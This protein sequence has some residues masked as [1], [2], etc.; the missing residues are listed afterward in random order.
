VHHADK[1]SR[2]SWFALLPALVLASTV[3]VLALLAYFPFAWD[4]PHTVR[5]DVH[6]TA[7]GD[8]WF[9]ERNAARTS[10]SPEWL[11]AAQRAGCLAIDLEARPRFP[12]HHPA[13]IMMLAR[14]FWHTS[15]AVGQDD[16]N[17]LLWLRRRGSSDN[18][19][20]PFMVPDVFR[21]NHWARVR[22]EID[23]VRLA[24]IVDGKVRLHESLPP[25]TLK[26]WRSGQI[27]LGDEVHSGIGWRGEIR[28]AEVTTVGDSIDYVQAGLVVPSSY[29][30]FPDHIAPFPPPEASEWVILVF[31][32]LSFIPVGLLIMWTRRPPVRVLSATIMAFG[33]AVVLALGKFLFDGRHTSAADLVLQL[34]G[35]LIGAMLGQWWL[36]KAQQS[37]SASSD[38]PDSLAAKPT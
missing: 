2:T 17:L 14:D 11:V 8:L 10:G 32:L 19:D 25:A 26:D 16:R 33:I 4:P 29:F 15:F 34:L 12:Q 20:P 38:S 27:A 24:V 22:V 23:G 31:H 36:R 35:G 37:K 6:R 18:G 3:A 21:P 5:N 30:Y 9:G 1:G 28:R 7:E 13:S